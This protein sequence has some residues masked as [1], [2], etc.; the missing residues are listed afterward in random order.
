[1]TKPLAFNDESE[2]YFDVWER[3]CFFAG[4]L[5]SQNTIYYKD[6]KH[7][8]IVRLYND[9]PVSLGVVGQNYK[10]LKNKELC[11]G[12]EETFMQELTEDELE[13]VSRRDRVSYMGSTCI[14]DYIF[15]GIKANIGSEKSDVAFRVIVVN[16]YDGSSSFKL[17]H[18][19]IDYFCTNGMVTGSY[20]MIY[21]R[22]TSGL[23]IPALTD[24]V[25]KAI[26]IFHEQSEEWSRWTSK[27]I[28]N[29]TAEECFKAMP[30]ISERR[31]LQLMQQYK[32]EIVSHGPTLWALYSTA[33]FYA[34][35]SNGYFSVRDTGQ[36]NVASTL[37]DRENQVRGW[38]NTDEFLA[39]AA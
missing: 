18:G 7:K 22:H 27:K 9:V 10:L 11:E 31:V 12:V 26:E 28:S 25:R 17:Y 19:A 2:I 21:K 30:N 14:R 33:T 35:N 13:G 15:P 39:I 8:H 24:K 6:E 3:P 34:S 1:M 23:T 29:E 36:D 16:G 37:L 38:L 5:D 32:Q 4:R 20:D